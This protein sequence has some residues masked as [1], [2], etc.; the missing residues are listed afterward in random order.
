MAAKQEL[1]ESGADALHI[2]LFGCT[3]RKSRATYPD[4]STDDLLAKMSAPSGGDLYCQINGLVDQ[5]PLE[6]L[7]RREQ[8]AVLLSEYECARWI[9]KMSAR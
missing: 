8:E 5:D 3:K 6:G 4:D 9:R 2:N 7:I 1:R